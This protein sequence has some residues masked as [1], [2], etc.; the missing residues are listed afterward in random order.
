MNELQSFLRYTFKTEN[1]STF[2]L[3]GPGS[4]GMEAVLVNLIEPGDKV[5]VCVGGYFALRMTQMVEK[6][7]GN[8]VIVKEEWGRAIKPEKLEEAL[9][10]NPDT[11]LVAFVHAE[12]STGALS[13]IKTLAEL[14][15]HYGAL[16]AVDTVTSLGACEIRVDEWEL[17]AVY[18][19]SQK[20]LACVAGMAP[21]TFGRRAV[22]KIKNR[23]SKIMSWFCDYNLLMAYWSGEKRTYHHTAPA[24]QFYGLHTALEILKEEGI[25]NSWRRHKENSAKLI[26]R[27]KS[28]GLEPLVPEGERIPNLLT[29]K[30][31]EGV[32]EAKIRTELLNRHNLEVGA[33]LGELAGKI[34]RVGLMGYNSNEKMVEF[35]VNSFKD[36]L[37]V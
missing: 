31:P 10:E 33:G 12:T 7:G 34:W 35:C 23:K 30:V 22:E 4:L 9:K 24:N 20:G 3:S 8:L 36:L 27:F 14:A 11:K 26:S 18:S 17:D 6:F 15:H 1:E 37:K 5:I 32:D 16:V 13:D 19:C 25:E 29:I 21:I 2:V 28:I